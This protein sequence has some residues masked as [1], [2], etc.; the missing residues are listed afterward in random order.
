MKHISI[1]VAILITVAFGIMAIAQQEENAVFEL[2][3]YSSACQ[4][5]E[6]LEAESLAELKGQV[7]QGLDNPGW[8]P[9]GGIAYNAKTDRYFQVMVHPRKLPSYP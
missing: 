6:V 4:S 7:R 9:Q 2:C 3:T 1:G 8:Q 5:Y